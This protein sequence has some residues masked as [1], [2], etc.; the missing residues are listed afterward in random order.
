LQ[1]PNY[2][3]LTFKANYRT[4]KLKAYA[5]LSAAQQRR[6]GVARQI[7]TISTEGMPMWDTFEASFFLGAGLSVGIVLGIL[8]PSL[9]RTFRRRFR[10]SSHYAP[11]GKKL[12]HKL[13]INLKILSEG[14]EPNSNDLEEL[15]SPHNYLDQNSFVYLPEAF[16]L[17][18]NY[19]QIGNARESIKIYID[20]LTHE[21]VSKQETHRAL[22]ELSQVYASIGLQVRAFDTSIELFRRMPK[23]TEV[24]EHILKVCSSGFFPDKLNIALSIFKGSPDAKLRLNIAH[25]LCKIGEIQLLE[26]KKFG[27]ATDLA[28]SALR[29]ERS[30]GRAMILLWQATS[31]ELWQKVAHDP[32]MMWT[33]LAA[34]LEA[35]I[36]IY[37]NT[38]VSPAAGAKY[39]SIIIS[40]I[41][42]ERE[43]IES[44]TIV[45][46][47]FTR[48]LNKEKITLNIQKY[49]WASIFHASLLIQNSPELKNSRFLSDV[50]AI[51]GENQSYFDFILKQDEAA[52]IGYSSHYCEKCGSF[53]S[54]FAWKCLYCNAEETLKPIIMPSFEHS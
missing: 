52:R 17:A 48:T 19:F 28:R 27:N 46:N 6:S 30:S 54:S 32:K 36:Q 38:N 13:T 24:L 31:H 14:E 26:A 33:A 11:D 9:W 25:S 35:L 5:R 29:W 18:R 2:I 45:Q 7:S 23:N 1:K 8:F 12:D 39:L 41:S 43:A 40:K 42:N 49:L 15:I 16:V 22:F 10:K 50:L 51:L 53:S 44:Y 37:S 4:T 34:D 47:E 20:I 21:N 3:I